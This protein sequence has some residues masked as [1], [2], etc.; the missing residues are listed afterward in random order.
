MK[1]IRLVELAD[2]KSGY[3]QDHREKS[4]EEER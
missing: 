3:L 2:K 1:D 4:G